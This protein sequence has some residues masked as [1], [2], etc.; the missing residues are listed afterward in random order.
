MGNLGGGSAPA[1]AHFLS[2]RWPVPSPPAVFRTLYS[3]HLES[4][5]L[6]YFAAGFCM[7]PSV[8]EEINVLDIKQDDG[9]CRAG[10]V[11]SPSPVV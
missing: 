7:M 5:F 9:S 11:L 4:F 6:N 8:L 1:F 10:G 3:W 2:K